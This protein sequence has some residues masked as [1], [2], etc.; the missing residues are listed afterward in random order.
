MFHQRSLFKGT[1]EMYQFFF[2]DLIGKVP[3]SYLIVM[4]GHCLFSIFIIEYIL[5][6]FDNP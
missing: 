1:N 4:L 2:Q 6:L 5:Y 3:L